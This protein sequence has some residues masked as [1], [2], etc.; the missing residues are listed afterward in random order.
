MGKRSRASPEVEVSELTVSRHACKRYRQRIAFVSFRRAEIEII[1]M[2]RQSFP[3]IRKP[4]DIYPD[5]VNYFRYKNCVIVIGQEGTVRTLFLENNSE[6]IEGVPLAKA[7]RKINRRK[8][9][10]DRRRTQYLVG[11]FGYRKSGRK[12][13]G[14]DHDFL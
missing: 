2:V 4:S 12:V 9:K 3:V 10:A 8:R 7:R 11:R 5:D 14:H 1:R 13:N 6:G